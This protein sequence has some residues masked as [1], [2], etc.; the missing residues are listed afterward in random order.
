VTGTAWFDDIRVMPVTNVAKDQSIP[1]Y[2]SSGERQN[3]GGLLFAVML[4]L[5]TIATMIAIILVMNN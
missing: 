3:T 4:G 2:E 5:V 1:V